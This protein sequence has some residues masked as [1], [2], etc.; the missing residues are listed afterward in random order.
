WQHECSD[1]GP[2][3]AES[4]SNSISACSSGD[5]GVVFFRCCIESEQ[6]IDN[7]AT[8]K[9]IH[10]RKYEI[11]GIIISYSVP[12]WFTRYAEIALAH[13]PPRS[14]T[15]KVIQLCCPSNGL[16]GDQTYGNG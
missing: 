4:R 14:G 15:P 5:D 6:P 16:R 13:T 9:A 8:I 3:A 10:F 1:P 12:G 2:T 11:M 7:N